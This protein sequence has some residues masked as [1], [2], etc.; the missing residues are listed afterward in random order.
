MNKTTGSVTCT[1][2]DQT[3]TDELQHYFSSYMTNF[4]M[5]SL[6]STKTYH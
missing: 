4:F 2:L 1:D 6:Q 3:S 5:L